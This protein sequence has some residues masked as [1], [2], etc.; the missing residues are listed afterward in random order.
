MEFFDGG[1]RGEAIWRPDGRLRERLPAGNFSEGWLVPLLLVALRDG[2]ARGHELEL[3]VRALGLRG[4][5]EAAFYRVLRRME[6]ESLLDSQP[7][8]AETPLRRYEITASGEAYLDAV[9]GALEQYRGEIDAFLRVCHSRSLR[10]KG[11]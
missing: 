3:G 7:P 4:V 2:P 9:T 1:S 11:A 6:E 8:G 10:R 5:R